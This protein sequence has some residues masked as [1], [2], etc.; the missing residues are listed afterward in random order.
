MNGSRLL[1]LELTTAPVR[2][3]VTAKA[4]GS[5]AHKL[6]KIKV[7]H[8]LKAVGEKDISSLTNNE[9]IMC[10]ES[11]QRPHSLTFQQGHHHHH[12]HH[13]KNDRNV[14]KQIA[15]K[16][17]VAQKVESSSASDIS[18]SSGSNSGDYSSNSSYSSSE[19]SEKGENSLHSLEVNDNEE[20]QRGKLQTRLSESTAKDQTGKSKE[21]ITSGTGSDGSSKGRSSEDSS[22]ES[23]RNSSGSSESSSSSDSD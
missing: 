1:S 9:A 13:H 8:R 2:H 19:D 20:S 14:K 17:A 23:S 5:A 21:I 10:I 11:I 3:V 16:I 15:K 6:E 12:H 7:G 22:G 18:S 4:P